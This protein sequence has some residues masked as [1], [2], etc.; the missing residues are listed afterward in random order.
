M[1][2]WEPKLPLGFPYGRDTWASHMGRLHSSQLSQMGQC[3]FQL[4]LLPYSMPGWPTWLPSSWAGTN[5]LTT[6]FMASL[7][8]HLMRIMIEI[9]PPI[10]S[11][12][13]AGL[14]FP[15]PFPSF[16]NLA[17]SNGYIYFQWIQLVSS[18]NSCKGWIVATR[19]KLFPENG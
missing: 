12:I 2:L 17:F 3:F 18:W 13:C 11:N 7:V 10:I 8:L 4:G 6:G 14:A 9:S 5:S 1:I 16:S 15:S 19:V